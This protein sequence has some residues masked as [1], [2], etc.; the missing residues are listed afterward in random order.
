MYLVR[1]GA[2]DGLEKLVADLGENPIALIESLGLRQSQFRNPN[3]YIA[4]HKVAELMELCSTHC[5]APLFGMMLAERQTS[6][7]LGD[8]PVLV[9]TVQ[10]VGQALEAG[11]NYLYLHA[12]GVKLQMQP[13]QQLVQLQLHF[14]FSIARGLNQLVQMSVGQLIT[15]TAELL[16]ANRIDFPVRLRQAAPSHGLDKLH[17]GRFRNIK[18]GQDFDGTIVRKEHLTARNQQNTRALSEHFSS[19]LEHLQSR[20]P[21]NLEHQVKDVIGRLLPSGDCS[22][23]SVAASLN[24]HPRTLQTKLQQQGL[25]YRQLLQDTRQDLAEQFLRHQSLSI[26][27]LALQLGYSE[28]AVFSRHFKKW[29]GLSPRQWQNQNT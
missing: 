9:S 15:F 27:D 29:T 13:Q 6:N 5:N 24:L 23:E 2:V 17:N 11:N 26:T 1:S 8:L 22:I 28:V 18:F 20:Y 4:Y 25:S 21:N 12:S 10:N 3:T 14:N 16:G 7:A 19:Y